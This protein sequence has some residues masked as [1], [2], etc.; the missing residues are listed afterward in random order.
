[1]ILNQLGNVVQFQGD[2]K[3]ARALYKRA[4]TIF[5]KVLGGDHPYTVEA[6]NNLSA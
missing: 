2:L 6:R 3:Q 5:S 1:M 4:V